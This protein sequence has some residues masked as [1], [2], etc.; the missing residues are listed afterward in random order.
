VV[1]IAPETAGSGVS[2]SKL[3]CEPG[4]RHA[5]VG[6]AAAPR[7]RQSSAYSR[8]RRRHRT[9]ARTTDQ[10]QGLLALRILA[11]DGLQ[12][13]DLRASSDALVGTGSLD[14]LIR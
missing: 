12:R 13:L 6:T 10:V 14:H 1:R 11:D 5:D 7:L 2:N 3:R 4:S 8:T 9:T